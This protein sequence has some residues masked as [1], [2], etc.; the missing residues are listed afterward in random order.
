VDHGDSENAKWIVHQWR[1]LCRGHTIYLAITHLRP[2]VDKSGKRLEPYIEHEGCTHEV[3]IQSQLPSVGKQ[4]R[5]LFR[6][7]F[8]FGAGFN[9][10]PSTKELDE[11]ALRVCDTIGEFIAGDNSLRAEGFTYRDDDRHDF[12]VKFIAIAIQKNTIT[13]QP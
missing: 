8:N 7:Q 9:R 5:Y 11:C 10:Y 12:W 3:W 1:G 13:H 4:W 2:G 6:G